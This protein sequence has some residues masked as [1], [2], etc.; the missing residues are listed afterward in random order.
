MNDNEK[1]EGYYVL[2]PHVEPTEPPVTAPVEANPSTLAKVG[3]VAGKVLVAAKWA[4]SIPFIKSMI[5]TRL[6]QAGI[7]GAVVLAVGD[8]ALGG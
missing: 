5:G 1:R 7:V 6:A 8:K 2:E 3:K 4:W